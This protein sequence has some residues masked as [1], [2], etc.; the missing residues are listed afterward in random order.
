M[1]IIYQEI[2]A[3]KYK[4]S[5]KLINTSISSSFT[6]RTFESASSFV[7]IILFFTCQCS[8]WYPIVLWE[9][10]C[11]SWSFLC[12]PEG[13]GGWSARGWWHYNKFGWRRKG[14]GGEAAPADTRVWLGRAM[15]A[16]LVKPAHRFGEL[17]SEKTML[18]CESI[19]CLLH[20]EYFFLLF[21][22]PMIN[23]CWW[24]LLFLIC[25]FWLGGYIQ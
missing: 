2:K 11:S 21:H 23:L 1:L 25:F 18:L 9:S 22:F 16:G 14:W 13:Q 7:A 6:A 17:I 19:N 24:A 4:E 8:F 10:Q 12:S 15:K 20:S 3:I 5:V